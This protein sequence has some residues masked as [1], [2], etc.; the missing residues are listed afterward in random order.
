MELDGTLE[1]WDAE[2]ET[3]DDWDAEPE[4]EPETAEPEVAAPVTTVR[5][6]KKGKN[7]FKQLLAEKDREG[8]SENLD[9]FLVGVEPKRPKA[10]AEAERAA[11]AA[12]KKERARIVAEKKEA[13]RIAAEREP[14]T[15][16]DDED[17]EELDCWDQDEP[18]GESSTGGA[19][20]PKQRYDKASLLT[21]A[22]ATPVDASVSFEPSFGPPNTLLSPDR[23][24]LFLPPP[25]YM[26]R[27]LRGHHGVAV[28]QMEELAVSRVEAVFGPM[29]RVVPHRVTAASAL[30][31][32]S[33]EDKWKR[34]DSASLS[35]AGSVDQHDRAQSGGNGRAPAGRLSW[36]QAEGS[37]LRK[38]E[39][40]WVSRRGGDSAEDQTLSQVNGILNKLTLEKFDSLLEKFL[41]LPIDS[42]ELL[43][44][45]INLIF[46]KATSEEK[47]CPLYAQLC[48]QLASKFSEESV[49]GMEKFESESGKKMSFRRLLLNQCQEEFEKEK[50]LT[51]LTPAEKAELSAA[52]REMTELTARKTKVRSLGNIIFIGELFKEK[53][54][55]EVIMHECVVRL[56]KPAAGTT[57]TRPDEESLE[58]LCKLL[59]TVGKWLDHD[60]AQ[61]YMK[62]YFKMIDK[63]RRDE[64][65]CLR[66]RFMLQE[67]EELR[68][69]S[70]QPRIKVDGPKTLREVHE[71]AAMEDRA[72][73][74]GKGTRK[75][76]SGVPGNYQQSP[77][78]I[79]SRNAPVSHSHAV[80]HSLG[81]LEPPVGQAAA[82]RNLGHRH[83]F[84]Q[85]KIDLGIFREQP[86]ARVNF[87]GIPLDDYLVAALD[88]A[89]P[90]D[91]LTKWIC[92]NL[93]ASYPSGAGLRHEFARSVARSAFSAVQVAVPA[94][95]GPASSRPHVQQQAMRKLT[96]MCPFL[97]WSTKGDQARRLALLDEVAALCG[98]S[99]WMDIRSIF[100]CLY[101]C[102]VFDSDIFLR[103]RQHAAD[104]LGSLDA[105]QSWMDNLVNA[106]ESDSLGG[107]EDEEWRQ[108]PVAASSG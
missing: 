42:P 39:N 74:R 108:Q 5:R 30:R 21:L 83:D 44:S 103:W 35:T 80:I 72:H 28:P 32:G 17:E 67:L 78:S 82:T 27:M 36:R 10:V 93:G 4:P 59:S 40:A 88:G 66:T 75:R 16:E 98:R 19:A 101:D 11:A 15:W 33:A 60:K 57:A 81:G 79:M 51:V 63:Y 96:A 9:A 49:Q 58:C 13:A 69:A 23:L 73:D 89:V 77:S 2:E 38:T 3:V 26:C 87:A 31:R 54:L 86:P 8:V 99:N 105:V 41:A 102:E 84:A 45:T 61:N 48:K 1:E 104:R 14:E 68:A 53:M 90:V 94:T 95:A 50:K 56:L 29:R 91:A 43:R 18:D 6:Q 70:W 24:L 62:Q 76:R 52:D 71:D 55:N 46:D 7:R 34:R 100:T 12:A 37:G 97:A 20:A 65:F 47:F 25:H 22:D 92:V 85:G 106:M 107:S 64:G